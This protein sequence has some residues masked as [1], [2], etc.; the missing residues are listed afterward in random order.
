MAPPRS[1]ATPGAYDRGQRIELE[2]HLAALTAAKRRAH[3][4]R[5]RARLRQACPH[6]DAF[7]DVL[8]RGGELLTR[9]TTAVLRLL[10]EYDPG[11]LDAALAD[12]VAR[13][14]LSA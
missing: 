6:A 11:E 2:A 7:L 13:E 1:R 3:D 10:D 12:A 9:H 8:A 4:L 5:G 14:T